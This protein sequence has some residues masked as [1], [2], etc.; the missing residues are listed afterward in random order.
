MCHKLTK[1]EGKFFDIDGI[2]QFKAHYADHLKEVL[3]R[4]NFIRDE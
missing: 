3:A 4:L 1:N 2:Y